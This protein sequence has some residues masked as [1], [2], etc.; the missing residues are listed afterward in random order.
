MGHIKSS[1]K[2]S[3]IKFHL[4]PSGWGST[5]SIINQ[6]CDHLSLQWLSDDPCFFFLIAIINYPHLLP[7]QETILV[8]E[9]QRSLDS[10]KPRSEAPNMPSAQGTCEVA[11]NGDRS[12]VVGY[13]FSSPPKDDITVH[14]KAWE[15][16][17]KP[18]IMWLVSRVILGGGVESKLRHK[19]SSLEARAMATLEDVGGKLIVE[20]ANQKNCRCRQLHMY[21][22][23]PIVQGNIITHSMC[24]SNFALSSHTLNLIKI[25]SPHEARVPTLGT[26]RALAMRWADAN[27]ML[28]L[29][30]NQWPPQGAFQPEILLQPGTGH[31]KTPRHPRTKTTRL[32]KPYRRSQTEINFDLLRSWHI[33]IGP[34]S[35]WPLRVWGMQ[36]SSACSSCKGCRL[37]PVTNGPTRI[38]AW[39]VRQHSHN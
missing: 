14:F 6:C 9:L 5:S 35:T 10:K 15:S 30:S 33:E 34:P 39:P 25:N 19:V 4:H 27:L 20:G 29:R 17:P 21:I 1:Q 2:D 24:L 18:S 38:G 12:D 23:G 36:T 8:V 32:P 11:K 3:E 22:K 26:N 31:Y 28:G 16:Q 7:L 13:I 37:D